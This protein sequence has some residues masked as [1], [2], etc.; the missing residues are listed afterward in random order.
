MS[1]NPVTSMDE[2]PEATEEGI[3]RVIARAL[4]HNDDNGMYWDRY[5]LAARLLQREFLIRQLGVVK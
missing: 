1:S 4:G 5:I 2:R 3:A